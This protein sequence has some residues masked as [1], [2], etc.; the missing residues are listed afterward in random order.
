MSYPG[1]DPADEI[2]TNPVGTQE[3]SAGEPQKLLYKE[4]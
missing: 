2:Q 3:P 4:V 1:V